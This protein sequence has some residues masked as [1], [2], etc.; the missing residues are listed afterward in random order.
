MSTQSLY[1]QATSYCARSL[2]REERVDVFLC[3]RRP[4]DVSPPVV[5]L[6]VAVLATS[7]QL[8]H[9]TMLEKK[10]YTV[11]KMKEV[12]E[13]VVLVQV[14]RQLLQCNILAVNLQ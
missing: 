5:K 4:S 13:R 10:N 1:Q 12:V 3:A 9:G 11:L 6:V 8:G 14:N 7:D 2:V